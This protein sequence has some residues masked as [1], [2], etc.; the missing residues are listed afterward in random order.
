MEEIKKQELTEAE[1]GWFLKYIIERGT[2]V[3]THRSFG[4]PNEKELLENNLSF[5]H[6][7]R[8]EVWFFG[9]SIS[10]EPVIQSIEKLKEVVKSELNKV[11]N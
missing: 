3:N 9:K 2:N 5:F 10:M 6:C 7:D 8:N 11:T 4:C 1:K